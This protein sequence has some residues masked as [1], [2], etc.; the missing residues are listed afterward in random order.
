MPWVVIK[1]GMVVAD[2]NEAVLREYLC[3]SPGCA[4]VAEHAIAAVRELGV[5]YA[6][7]PEHAAVAGTGLPLLPQENG[8]QGK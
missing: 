3:D 7:C 2:G 5:V 6:V 8:D 4:Q 1:T